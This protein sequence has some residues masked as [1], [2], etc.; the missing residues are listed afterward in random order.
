[1]TGGRL[2]VAHV[3]DSRLYLLAAG[4][5]RQVTEDDSWMAAMLTRDDQVDPVA[6]RYHPMRNVLT[7]AVGAGTRTE[8]HVSEE[9]LS[10]GE[11]L[12]LSTDG[13]HGVLDEGRLA[14]ILVDA[15]EPAHAAGELV[16]AALARGSTDNCT[17]VVLH[18]AP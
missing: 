9:Q 7:N 14:Q 1:V 6:L 2:A 16:R 18:Y 12:L 4:R 3:G 15:R 5:L 13:V 17:A 10:G 8:V 11:C